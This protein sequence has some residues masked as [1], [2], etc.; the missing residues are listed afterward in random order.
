MKQ[1]IVGTYYIG[2]EQCELIIFEG[3]GGS[4]TFCP[5]RGKLPIIKIGVNGTWIDVVET[6]LHEVMEFVITR[7]DCRYRPSN[8]LSHGHDTYLMVFNHPQFS[9]VCARAAD[10]LVEALPDLAKVYKKWKK[11]EN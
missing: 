5:E 8:D 3:N 10:F 9:K 11:H 6:L 1:K 4:Y 2:F 7:A